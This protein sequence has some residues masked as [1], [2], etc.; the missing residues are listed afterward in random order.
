MSAK[1]G[2]GL[3][4]MKA[5]LQR[6]LDFDSLRDRPGISNLRHL[7]LVEQAK[8]A[9]ARARQALVDRGGALSEEFVL[10]DLQHARNALEEISGRRAPA[11]L[12][13]H[14]RRSH[15]RRATEGAAGRDVARSRVVR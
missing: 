12:W 13:S 1:T 7:G 6:A 2:T 3:D 15:A 8:Q 14:C 9:L 11:S 10:A 5:E 4:A